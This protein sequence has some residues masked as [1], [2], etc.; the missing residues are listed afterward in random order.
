YFEAAWRYQHREALG[1][2]RATLAGVAVDSKVSA[3]YLPLVWEIL[4]AENET[5]P[6]AKLQSM[7]RQL[8]A[9]GDGD[10]DLLRARRLEMRDFVI[11]PRRHTAMQ[12]AAPVVRGLPPGSQ[13][14]LNWKLRAFAAHRRESDPQA[15]RNDTDPPPVVPPIPKYPGLHQE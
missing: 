1:K 8:P 5:G 9:P 4:H 2:P 6:I 14:L 12:Y 13:P 10:P 3:K 11:K 15:L 7:W